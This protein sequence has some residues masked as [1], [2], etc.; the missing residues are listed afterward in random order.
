[1]LW[2]F[3]LFGRHKVLVFQFQVAS[4]I[5]EKSHTYEILE[6]ISFLFFPDMYISSD[7]R[8]CEKLYWNVF[9]LL[10]IDGWW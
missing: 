5:C 10:I 9:L 2:S 3:R 7:I 6:N 8:E 1:M 4:K